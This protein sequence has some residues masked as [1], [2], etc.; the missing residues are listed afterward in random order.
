MKLNKAKAKDIAWHSGKALL[1]GLQLLVLCFV[2]SR[3]IGQFMDFLRNDLIIRKGSVAEALLFFLL[4]ITAVILFVTFW[5]YYDHIDDRS[6]NRFRKAYKNEEKAPN[7]LRE[8]AYRAGLIATVLCA[9]PVISLALLLALRATGMGIFLCFVVSIPVSLSLVV[10]LS[11]LRIR[12]RADLWFSQR[13]LPVDTDKARIVPRILYAVVLFGAVAALIL[14]G[15]T[16]LLPFFGSLIIGIIRLLWK[17][18]LIISAVLIL[19]LF[20]YH[21]LRRMV[22]RRKFLKQLAKMRD[23]GELSFAVHGHPYLSAFWGRVPFGLTITDA[24]HPEG[25][26]KGDITYQV[27][28]ANCRFRR[29]MVILCD[30]NVFRFVHSIQFR[31]IAQQNW[32]GLSVAS[33]RIVSMPVA[34]FYSS[35]SFDFPEGEGKRILLVDP[36]PRVLC[37]HG[38]REGEL[39]TLDNASEVFGYTV[40]GKKSFLNLLERT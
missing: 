12:R 25:K 9:A 4:P 30:N 3:S 16:I 14:L 32:G 15:F 19:W 10:G 34:S 33:S 36:A 31:T 29:G 39:I 26:R 28:F 23:R 6:F 21:A 7:L 11:L 35:H 27:A 22:D 20:I 24:P 1:C 13:N 38:F 17:A 2:S 37:M 40:Y 8:P 5:R 18:I